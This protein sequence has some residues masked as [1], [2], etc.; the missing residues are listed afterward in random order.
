MKRLEQYFRLKERGSTPATEMRAGITTFM[1][2]AYIIFTNPAILSSA[3]VPVNSAI[4]A[5]CLA[6]GISTIL[7]G[8]VTNYPMCL[9]A[10]IGL[11]AVVAF[12]IVIGLN[13]TWQTAMGVIVLEGLIVLGF[14]ATAM[15]QSVMEAIPD[16][17]KQ[18]IAVAI[19][20]FITFIGL[21]EGGFIV[22][23]PATLV[24]FG[25]FTQPVCLLSSIG[26]LITGTL[27]IRRARGALLTG[28]IA[29]ALLGMLPIWHLT[30]GLASAGSEAAGRNSI[31]A[32]GPIVR[33]PQSL[34]AVPHD[35]S[36]MFAFDLRGAAKLALLPLVFACLMTDFFDTMGT[37][38]AVGARAGLLDKQGRMPRIKS[39]LVVDSLAAIIGGAFGCSSNTCFIE[40]TTGIAEGGRTGLTAITCGILFLLA[41]FCTP[42]IAVVGAGVEISPHVVKHP[43]TAAALI[44][45]GFLMM[46]GIYEIN[47]R[48]PGEGLPA[49]LTL[50]VMP[51]TFSITHGIGAGIV[52]YALWKLLAGKAREVPALMWPITGLFLLVFLLPA[53]QQWFAFAGH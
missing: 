24:T 16:S 36:T 11:N 28:I 10:G 38:I 1:A 43:V 45:V 37:A 12:T 51:F 41:T 14:S 4:T 48:E 32:W 52:S 23:H 26:L 31:E 47:W 2:M 29:T 35:F 5:T 27:L 17:L 15:R 46:E 40:S 33:I 53:L 7:M 20:L 44:C 8:I 25:D 30:P 34:V 9:A 13:Q 42:L 49:F 21:Q 22:A 6:A 18:A 3:K 39:L 50:V 19:G